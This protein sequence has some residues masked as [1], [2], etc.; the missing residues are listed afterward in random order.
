[1][2]NSAS[3]RSLLTRAKTRDRLAII[4][5]VNDYV[6]QLH[7]PEL[8]GLSGNTIVEALDAN[9]DGI[10]RTGDDGFEAVANVY[11]T[12]TYGE[13]TSIAELFPAL[14]KGHIHGS[15]VEVDDVN[16]DTSSFYK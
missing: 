4:K 3:P 2:A 11:V 9:P 12:L 5:A 13:D 1:M 15:K 6:H 7:A 8:S 10:F 14:V 16:V